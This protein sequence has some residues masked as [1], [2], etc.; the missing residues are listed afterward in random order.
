MLASYP[1][2]KLGSNRTGVLLDFLMLSV[3]WTTLSSELGTV[4]VT[5]PEG[6][7][8]GVTG[9]TVGYSSSKT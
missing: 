4:N 2:A 1:K 6:A 3:Y 5:D 8:S 9:R 7:S